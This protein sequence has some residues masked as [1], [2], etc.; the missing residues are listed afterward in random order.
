MIGAARKAMHALCAG[1]RFRSGTYWNR[2]YLLGGNS[3]RGSYGDLAEFKAK[4]IN[5]F[6]ARHKVTAVVDWGVGDGNQAA[7]FTVPSYVGY[8]VSRTAIDMCR[9]RFAAHEGKEFIL[10]H[11]ER[12][13][14]PRKA[15][16]SMSLDVVY[17]LVEDSLYESHLWNLF[18]SSNRFVCIYS[19]DFDAVHTRHVRHRCFS[20][21]VQREFPEFRL[22]SVVRNEYPF[23]L[24]DPDHTSLSDFYFY[25][26]VSHEDE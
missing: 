10:F 22:L 19:S 21:R 9:R 4:V 7:L 26:K 24:N 2:R 16:L 3:G 25:E 13:R 12:V 23:E 20:A 14:P 11:G 18:A 8:D 17:H 6:V 15:A 1:I 5:E